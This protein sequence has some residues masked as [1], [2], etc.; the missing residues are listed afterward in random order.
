MAILVPGTAGSAQRAEKDRRHGG[1]V[2]ETEL[3]IGMAIV[4]AISFVIVLWW[5]RRNCAPALNLSESSQ[6]LSKMIEKGDKP[7]A[8]DVAEIATRVVNKL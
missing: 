6:G 1:F 2:T 8:E 7:E 4:A 3:K 5:R